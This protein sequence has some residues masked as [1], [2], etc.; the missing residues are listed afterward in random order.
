[1]TLVGDA[2]KYIP[3][4]DLGTQFLGNIEV[5][6][7]GN[8]KTESDL[9]TYLGHHNEVFG[10]TEN[11][12]WF[13]TFSGY[14]Y[15]SAHIG[16]I[17]LRVLGDFD[18]DEEDVLY[19]VANFD[20]STYQGTITIDV[21]GTMAIEDLLTQTPNMG[22][23]VA[24]NIDISVGKNL[25]FEEFLSDVP[26]ELMRG[27]FT[28]SVN[29]HVGGDL[30]GDKLLTDLGGG[31][32]GASV[33]VSVV[34]SATVN[35]MLYE[36][37]YEKNLRHGSCHDAER[38]KHVRCVLGR[39]GRSFIRDAAVRRRSRLPDQ[40]RSASVHVEER[41]LLSLRRGYL[42]ASDACR[43]HLRDDRGR[44]RRGGRFHDRHSVHRRRQGGR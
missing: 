1:M 24:A 3:N 38:R 6:V 15:A 11:D 43:R 19:D 4:G 21:R 35:K 31:I 27:K 30:R 28:G 9:F 29:V 12:P 10:K 7:G 14:T 36:V 34:G 42:V 22:A 16:N 39:H 8:L 2:F 32:T 13:T 44:P 17:T 25:I 5:S 23:L 37:A 33:S 26:N 18:G 20:H 41:C 40:R